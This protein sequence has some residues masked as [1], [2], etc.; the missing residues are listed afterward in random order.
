[1]GA[2]NAVAAI[3][4]IATHGV[5]AVKVAI[6]EQD[7]RITVAINSAAIGITRPTAVIAFRML[8]AAIVAVAPATAADK[9]VREYAVE[10]LWTCVTKA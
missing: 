5:A 7:I 1:M 10:D 3:A 4:T 6:L 8:A 2:L 9:T